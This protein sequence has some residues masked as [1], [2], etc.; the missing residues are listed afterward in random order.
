MASVSLLFVLWTIPV[1]FVAS[2]TTLSNLTSA[3]PWLAPI[4]HGHT[5]LRQLLES[6]LSTVTL[7]LFIMVLP[8]I[9]EVLGR[10]QGEESLSSLE[11]NV[12]RR[13]F[14]FVVL[15]FFFL[16]TLGASL[17]SI[18]EDFVQHPDFDSLV[19]LLGQSIPE[20]STFFCSYIVLNGLV[21]FPIYLL[22]VGDLFR[23]WRKT[24]KG[25]H[26]GWHFNYGVEY[27]SYLL[28]FVISVCY[29]TIAPVILLF[30]CMFFGVGYMFVKHQVL[31]V[32]TPRYESGGL[33]WPLVFA[34]MVVGLL[35]FQ[36]TFMGV[37][38]LK[39]CPIQATLVAPLI[40]AT[41]FFYHDVVSAFDERCCYLPL[42]LAQTKHKK[43]FPF[44]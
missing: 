4:I 3:F 23:V 2:L 22:N 44:E 24:G 16:N 28:I 5:A 26:D 31:F 36:G 39:G 14:I 19:R 9:L 8:F 43:Y 7:T 33:C 27:P 12:F 15:E 18:L 35:C 29:S 21:A 20:Y 1:G 41:V 30:A 34:R 17:L 10:F 25:S 13:F 11:R 42:S 32:A 40:G 37:L 38:G 6:F